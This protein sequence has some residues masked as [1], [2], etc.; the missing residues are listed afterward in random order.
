MVVERVRRAGAVTLG[1]TNVPE[2]AS[3]WQSF[4]AVFGVSPTTTL[5][6]CSTIRGARCPPS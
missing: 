2:M 3:D 4:N 5:D 1:K 6:T